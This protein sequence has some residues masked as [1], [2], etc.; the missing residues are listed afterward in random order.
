MIREKN[1]FTVI[2]NGKI[3]KLGKGGII[4]GVM[5]TVNPYESEIVHLQKDDVII[6]FTDGITEA[7]N[8][9][10]K[11]FSDKRL[12]ELVL[13]IDGKPSQEILDSI[14]EEVQ[15]F[16]AGTVQSDDMTIIVIKI[17]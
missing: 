14:K 11:E 12:E 2:R 1:F 5:K 15:S 13:S 7:M 3:R 9:E 6:L 17:I 8:K 16:A 10:G 4:L